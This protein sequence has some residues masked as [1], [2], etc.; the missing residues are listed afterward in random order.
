MAQQ[1]FGNTAF[2]RM[3]NENDAMLNKIKEIIN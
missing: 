2:E 3:V 1:L